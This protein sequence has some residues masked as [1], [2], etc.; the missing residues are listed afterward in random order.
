MISIKRGRNNWHGARTISLA[1]EL[2][3]GNA[4]WFVDG[5]SKRSGP[6]PVFFGRS[7]LARH[8]TAARQPGII[9]ATEFIGSPG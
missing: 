5:T 2:C 8:A 3:L 1:T 7:F 4:G 6:K 9:I